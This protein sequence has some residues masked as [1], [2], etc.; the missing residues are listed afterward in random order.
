MEKVLT[1]ELL[2]SLIRATTV[3]E[4]TPPERN[5]P[6]GTS[7]I[8]R[9]RTASRRISRTRSPASS[10]EMSIFFEKSGCQ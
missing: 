8:S 5:A 6:S 9:T 2:T 4:S 7:D 1:G 10:S 3:E